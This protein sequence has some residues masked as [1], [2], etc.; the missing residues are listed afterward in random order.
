M[1]FTAQASKAHFANCDFIANKSTGVGGAVYFR[2]AA[3][4]EVAFGNC[5]FIGNT[6][7]NTAGAV[8]SFLGGGGWV[9]FYNCLFTGNKATSLN[10]GAVYALGTGNLTYLEHCTVSGNSAASGGGLSNTSGSTITAENCILFGNTDT[11]TATDAFAANIQNGGS[12]PVYASCVQAMPRTYVGRGPGCITTDPLFVDAN[13][14]D[15]V[16]GTSDDNCRLQPTSGCI[17]HGDNTRLIA[18]YADI[19]QNGNTAELNP[20]DLDGN[21][22]RADD[23]ATADGGVGTA[24]ISD[25]GAYEFT[26]ACRPDFDH[27][28]F[29]TGDDF[30]AFSAAFVAGELTSDYDKNGFVNGD[31]YD[32]FVVDFEAGC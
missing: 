12:I 14:A 24:P 23:P 15:N 22:R 30:D 31:D 29:L 4:S 10:G 2:S 1:S 5:R 28:G 8:G 3:N 17:D 27:D 11:D 16:S 7:D 18:D 21:P 25:M 19:D 9:R 20:L 13:G 6:S 32:S 26:P